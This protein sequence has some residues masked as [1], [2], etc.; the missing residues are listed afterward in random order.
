M[1]RM[2]KQARAFGVGMVLATQNPVD[3]DYKGLSNAGTWF[4]GRL[5]TEQDKD[6]LIDGLTSATGGDVSK[7]DYDRLISAIGKRV[8]LARNVHEKQ[9][10]LFQT[11]WAMNYLAG[12]MTRSQIP[13]L[14]ELVG[15]APAKA[16]AGK[17]KPAATTEAATEAPAAATVTAVVEETTGIGTETR[18]AAPA[19]VGE[20]FL[21]T[22][23]PLT[24][25]KAPVLY[26]P[27]LLAQANVA[28]ANA[29]YDVNT[30]MPITA[31]VLD[32]DPKGVINW[33]DNLVQAIDPNELDTPVKG[34]RFAALDRPYS[35]GKLMKSLATEYKDWIYNN[36]TLPVRENKS[37]K[38]Y[39]GPEVGDEAWED[40]R[41]EAADDKMDAEVDKL[42]SKYESKIKS[43]EAKL[44][45][46]QAELAED[47]AELSGRKVEEVGQARRD[48][49]RVSG[50]SQ[51]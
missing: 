40:K 30:V 49:H 39:A 21:P 11:R 26:R 51:A 7:S 45:K 50:Q 36:K 44:A 34:A 1:L 27:V 48:A 25:N 28:I 16:T 46:E 2:L 42:K 13:A 33:E 37:L 41:A 5:A 24:G 3:I 17:K 9:P 6:R 14:N 4:I 20:F 15:A 23:V 22:N 10:I 47:E 35:D 38:V 8:F 12:P 31:L 19:G 29:K 43:L 32:A 18:P